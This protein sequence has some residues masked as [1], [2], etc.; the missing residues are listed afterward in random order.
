MKIDPPIWENENV[1]KNYSDKFSPE[2]LKYIVCE[3]EDLKRFL[4]ENG[5][6]F[7]DCCNVWEDGFTLTF[8]KYIGEKRLLFDFHW[9]SEWSV[10]W[11]GSMK[12]CFKYFPS[13]KLLCPIGFFQIDS[14]TE[15]FMTK[16][17]FGKM[18]KNLI[19]LLDSQ[20]HIGSHET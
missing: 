3:N 17:I 14:I 6:K 10:Y 19:A 7:R 20:T 4:I 2:E 12:A 18:E 8:E 5:W 16:E 9:M 11:W 15:R 13:D 1:V